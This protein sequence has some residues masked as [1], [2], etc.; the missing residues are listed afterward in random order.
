VAIVTELRQL[1]KLDQREGFRVELPAPPAGSRL[2]A[3]VQE[4]GTGRILG[5][6]VLPAK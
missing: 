5:A 6:A 2:I 3:F 1:G 4:P